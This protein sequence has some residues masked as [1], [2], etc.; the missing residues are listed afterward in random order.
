MSKR[1]AALKFGAAGAV[2]ALYAAATTAHWRGKID[3]SKPSN[4]KHVTI[5]AGGLVLLTWAAALA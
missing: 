3:P 5:V 4:P 2:T 1:R